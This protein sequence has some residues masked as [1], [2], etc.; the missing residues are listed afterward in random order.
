[1]TGGAAG[2]TPAAS[3]TP[4]SRPAGGHVGGGGRRSL[5]DHRLLFVTGKGGVGKTSMAAGLALLSAQRGRRTLVCEIDAKG[6]LADSFECPGLRFAPTELAPNLWGMAMDTEESLREYLKLQLKV[7]MLGRIGPV[8]RTFDFVADAAPGVKEILTVGKLCYEVREQTYDL[9]VV[10]ASATGH[11]VG[12]LAAPQAINELVKV[13]RVRD[14]TR[15]M[16]DILGDPATT[17]AVIVTS[18]EEMPVAETLELAERLATETDVGL[19]A[20]LVNRVLPELFG[21]REE[22]VFDRLRQPAGARA[23]DPGPRT[24]RSRGGDPAARCRP[25]G[26]HAA[27]HPSRAPDPLRAELAAVS[28]CSTCPTCSP[29]PTACGPPEQWPSR[30]PPRSTSTDVARPLPGDPIRR[31]ATAKTGTL[32]QLLASR[33]IVVTCGSGGVGKT[34]TAAAAAAMAAAHLGGKVLVLTVDPARRLANA[35]G[36]EQFGNVET[37]VPDEPFNAAGV[38]PRG[39]LWAAMLDTKQS[40]DDLVRR[41]APDAET[42]DA[43]P[44]QPALPEHHRQ[45]RPEPRL[46][47]HGAAVRDPLVGQLRPDRGRHP[48]HPQRPRLPRGARADGRLLLQPRCCGWLIAPYRSPPGQRRL[49][50]LLPGGRPHPRLAVPGATSPSS[51]SCSR[52]CTTGSSSGPRRSPGCWPTAG[53]PSWW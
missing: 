2:S 11:V 4:R 46:H 8:A 3:S 34:T 40:W 47:R 53:P 1:M 30:W 14:Q 50:A 44:G 20:V 37:R 41:H 28:R 51:S 49:Q 36:L 10:D 24:G 48:A 22:E 43:H 13:G 26:G 39:E 12:Q 16:V 42:R 19:A 38:E 35:L 29:A 27:P 9:I 25:A 7:P 17:A 23:A 15:W 31:A 5:L 21:R 18:P 6:D 45:V 32:E 52:P 33:E